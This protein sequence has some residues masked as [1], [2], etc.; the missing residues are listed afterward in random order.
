MFP[1]SPKPLAAARARGGGEREG[2]V[3]SARQGEPLYAHHR[4]CTTAEQGGR[5][6]SA[7]GA[8]R[9]AHPCWRAPRRPDYSS[10]AAAA[11]EP[12]RPP[13]P[14]GARLSR[15]EWHTPARRARRG[16]RPPPG[17]HGVAQRRV[18]AAA[19]RSRRGR[20]GARGQL[21]RF[22]S[23]R[24]RRPA[25]RRAG[26][27]PDERRGDVPHARCAL[28]LH[29]RANAVGWA[30]LTRAH[31]RPIATAPRAYPPAAAVCA[32]ASLRA[33][34]R[35][36]CENCAPLS[37]PRASGPVSSARRRQTRPR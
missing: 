33:S 9:S 19:G 29:A 12:A 17:T 22:A 15:R 36:L 35:Q 34:G 24:G 27:V 20:N 1:L 23:D 16:L 28:A 30:C 37:P 25:R 14:R 18:G 2:T 6:R 3:V 31:P 21:R 13:G 7:R 5:G 4:S 26:V 10:A 11:Q 32:A 8:G